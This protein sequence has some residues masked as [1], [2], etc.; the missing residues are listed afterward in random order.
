MVAKARK[1]EREPAL[2]SCAREIF[3]GGIQI[4]TAG[5]NLLADELR[6]IAQATQTFQ[7]RLAIRAGITPALVHTVIMAVWNDRAPL[8]GNSII[9][10]SDKVAG[11]RP[12][13]ETT[14]EAIMRRGMSVFMSAVSPKQAKI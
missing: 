5:G 6:P 9:M 10:Q 4:G 14:K 7:G 11:D 12:T 8:L 13:R 3:P 2:D 1:L